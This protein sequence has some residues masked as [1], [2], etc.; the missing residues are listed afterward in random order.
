MS[1]AAL[2]LAMLVV[3]ATPGPSD[4][5]V[6]ARSL[7]S[8]PRSTLP[9]IVGIVA[10][11]AL[12]IA[13]SI[14]G[15]DVLA[16][17]AAGLWQAFHLACALYVISLGVGLLRARRNTDDDAEAPG[18]GSGFA[19]GLAVTLADPRAWLFYVAFLPAFIDPSRLGFPGAV[20]V[21]ILAAVI[22]FSVKGSY[23]LLAHRASARLRDR[24]WRRAMDLLSGSLLFLAGLYLLVRVLAPP[25]ATALSKVVP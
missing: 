22:I 10:A 24:R 5:V 2:G 25:D 11:D 4:F 3:S 16:R 19:S 14:A 8:G 7:Q 21:L 17:G 12:L 20:G 15:I 23:A 18:I 6:V 9:M 1:L 13:L